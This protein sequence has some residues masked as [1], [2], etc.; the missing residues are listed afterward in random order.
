MRN[1]GGEGLTGTHCCCGRVP[2]PAFPS[3]LGPAVPAVRCRA[4]A[5]A[6]ISHQQPSQQEL[7][8]LVPEGGLGQEPV[9]VGGLERSGAVRAGHGHAALADSEAQVLLQAGPAR[10]V[11][12]GGQAGKGLGGLGQQAQGTLLQHLALAQ[13]QHH[14]CLLRLLRLWL[15][16]CLPLDDLWLPPEAAQ[17]PAGP[18]HT[19]GLVHG[20]PP[21]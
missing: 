20:G 17:K 10:A 14:T 8:V 12:A 2:T 15:W 18:G 7:F 5:G 16:W 21:R 3:V 13:G 11:G 4:P 1:P 9:H 6:R 19:R